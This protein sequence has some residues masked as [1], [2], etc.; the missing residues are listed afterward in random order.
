MR[1]GILTPN[2]IRYPVNELVA[3]RGLRKL[4]KQQPGATHN[5]PIRNQIGSIIL[6]LSTAEVLEFNKDPDGGP[7][8]ISA[9]PQTSTMN[10][11]AGAAQPVVVR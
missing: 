8:G 1:T 7:L 6:Q 2:G 11:S 5:V 9:S 10:G 4:L 3:I